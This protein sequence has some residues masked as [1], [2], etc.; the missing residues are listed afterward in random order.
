MKTKLTYYFTE[1]NKV[2]CIEVFKRG[3]RN[4]VGSI[5]L[6][7]NIRFFPSTMSAPIFDIETMREI[8]YI[9]DELN[10]RN[11]LDYIIFKSI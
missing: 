8:T 2:P 7:K 4:Y 10:L 5:M 3:G 1:C 6:Y 9:M 11:P